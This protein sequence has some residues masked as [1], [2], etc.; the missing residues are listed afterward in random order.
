M[1]KNITHKE[2][3]GPAMKMIEPAEVDAYFEECVQHCMTHG[4]SRTEAESI[5][6]VNL[7]Y[8]AGY[9]DNETRARVERLFRCAHPIFGAIAEKGPPTPEEAFEM[10]LNWRLRPPKRSRTIVGRGPI[11]NGRGAARVPQGSACGQEP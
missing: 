8:Y 1:K 6:R 11:G 10:G 9:Y 4:K 5:E 3:Y 7:G 2:K